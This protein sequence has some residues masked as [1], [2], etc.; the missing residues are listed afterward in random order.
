MSPSKS[1]LNEQP[2]SV[3]DVD[4][5]QPL[6]PSD[7]PEKDEVEADNNETQTESNLDANKS[8]QVKLSGSLEYDPEP[9]PLKG[10]SDVKPKYKCKENTESKYCNVC[11]C[12]KTSQC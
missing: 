5:N 9:V 10:D 2:Q 8:P 6:S 11:S 12:S 4:E 3:G 1:A 7:K